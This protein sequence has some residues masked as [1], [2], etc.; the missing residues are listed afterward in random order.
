MSKILNTKFCKS[1]ETDLELT[2]FYKQGK[3][4]EKSFATLCKNCHNQ[5]RKQSPSYNTYYI[6]KVKGF[7]KL[8]L[9][10]QKEVVDL[11]YKGVRLTKV[12]KYTGVAYACLYCWRRKGLI[13]IYP[14][15]K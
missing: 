9:S 5:I 4:S 10:K 14:M 12:A 7:Q 1:C 15:N 3:H 8:P 2:N 11:I 6:P 13:L